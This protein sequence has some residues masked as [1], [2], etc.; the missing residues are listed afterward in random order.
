M[1]RH[2]YNYP[3]VPTHCSHLY[4]LP[5]LLKT[6]ACYVLD[7]S[8]VRGTPKIPIFRLCNS[9]THATLCDSCD[10]VW[11]ST[12]KKSALSRNTYW[13][14]PYMSH[15]VY[16]YH[17]VPLSISVASLLPSYSTSI[18]FHILFPILS[19]FHILPLSL[20]RDLLAGCYALCSLC[21]PP[22]AWGVLR[23]F[24]LDP[25]CKNLSVGAWSWRF[26]LTVENSPP[27]WTEGSC[28]QPS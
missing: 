15:I 16:P 8:L 1:V 17:A 5:T 4:N 13:P 27:Y 26:A 18:S 14:T 28:M 20:F 6:P 22:F 25:P 2:F 10:S 11:S 23:V 9:V 7:M 21:S 12:P 3:L 24:S 19:I